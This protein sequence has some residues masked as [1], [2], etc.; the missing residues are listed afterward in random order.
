MVASHFHVHFEFGD[1]MSIDSDLNYI[2]KH[3]SFHK[4]EE[5]SA[6]ISYKS[7]N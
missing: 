6:Q 3:N 4:I 7:R 1:C 2:Y 5:N